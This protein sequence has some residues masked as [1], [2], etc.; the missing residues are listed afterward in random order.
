MM[1]DKTDLD[2][3][4]DNANVV[5]LSSWTK[6]S[7][8]DINKNM[9]KLTGRQEK[10]ARA[11]AEGKNQSEAYREVYSKSCSWEPEALHNRAYELAKNS[12]VLVRIKELRAEII[13]NAAWKRQESIQLL[14]N[15]VHTA[16]RDSDKIRA[17]RELNL[18]HG[19]NEPVKIDHTSSDGSMS[20][21]PVIDWS[22]VSE[23]A[24]AEV[25]AARIER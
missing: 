17:I 3:D 20:P 12:D 5:Q 16:V 10:F 11:I 6:T 7:Q 2:N 9:K 4:Q 14:I 22:K 8:H 18:M 21:K 13:E 24:L 1:N 23:S 25:L 15:I 19:Y